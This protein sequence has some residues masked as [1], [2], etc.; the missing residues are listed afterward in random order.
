MAAKPTKAVLS[1]C[2]DRS[3]FY[4]VIARTSKKS[5]TI[6]TAKSGCWSAS[7]DAREAAER[8]NEELDRHKIRKPTLVVGVARAQVDICSATLPPATPAEIPQM[9]RNEV[10]RQFGE[11]PESAVVDYDLDDSGDNNVAHAFVLRPESAQNIKLFAEAVELE[12]HAILLRQYSVASLFARLAEQPDASGLLLNVLEESADLMVVQNRKVATD[13]TI[14]FGKDS[15]PVQIERLSSEILRTVA[16]N[17]ALSAVDRLFVFGRDTAANEFAST[18]RQSLPYGVDVLDP[19]QQ[20]EHA[21][22]RGDDPSFPMAALVGMV[23]DVIDDAAAI[24]FAMPKQPVTPPSRWRKVAFYSLSA[25]A[26]VAI[27]VFTLGGDLKELDSNIGDLEGQLEHQ[28]QMLKQLRTQTIIVDAVNQW[29]NTGVNWLDEIRD[30]TVRFPNEADA[31]V[32]RMSCMEGRVGG[33][34][35]MGVRVREPSIVSEMESSLRDS[36]RQVRSKRISQA[37]Q[38]QA[39]PCQFESTVVT[40]RRPRELYLE[41]FTNHPNGEPELSSASTGTSQPEVER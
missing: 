16:A 15:G 33:T 19:M 18:M 36:Y 12:V 23:R 27:C 41:S 11:L 4:F 13:R 21:G 10:G 26:A 2:W 29:E 25:A 8:I 6:V 32:D 1:V 24:N 39:F 40:R 5:T 9:V 35:S 14:H 20:T 31:I 22:I 17:P 3:R 30:I 28:K 7:F 38:G 37:D 34:I